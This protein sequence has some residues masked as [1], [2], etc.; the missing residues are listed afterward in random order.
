MKGKG[1]REVKII[2]QHLPGGFV[3]NHKTAITM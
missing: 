3:E 2:F 1:Y